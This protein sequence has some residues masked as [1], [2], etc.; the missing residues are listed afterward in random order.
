MDETKIAHIPR[1]VVQG[2]M[3][4]RE[5][6]LLVTD[7]RS[8]FVPETSNKVLLGAMLGGVIGA[9]IAQ[10][11]SSPKSVDYDR[12]A[13]AALAMDPKSVVVPHEAIRRIAFRRKLGT[14]QLRIEYVREDGKEKKFAA[15]VRPPEQHLKQNKARG[16]KPKQTLAAYADSVRQAYQRALPPAAAAKAEWGR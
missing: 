13:P 12:S 10:A 8:I 16:V 9:A 2:A 3:G 15:I 1:V 5:Y 4:L 11:A 14:H 7:R 6:G